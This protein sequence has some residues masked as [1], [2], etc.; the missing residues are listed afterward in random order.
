MK[1]RNGI[2]RFLSSFVAMGLLAMSLGTGLF[3][4]PISAL[5]QVN[6]SAT[7]NAVCDGIGGCNTGGAQG[8]GLS[9]VTNFVL[10]LLVL[11]AGVISVVMIVIGG[12]KYATSSGYSNEISSA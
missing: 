7:Q 8:A 11:V 6:S 1:I 12:I 4:S 3:L 9:K 10:N 2:H 5:A